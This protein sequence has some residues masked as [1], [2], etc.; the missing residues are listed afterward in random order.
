[1]REA[2][3]PG[4]RLSRARRSTKILVSLGML[5]LFL[6]LVSSLFVASAR[7]GLT[8]NSVRTYYV[9]E[10]SPGDDSLDGALLA[11]A[12]R[13]FAELVE[14]THLHILGGSMLLFLLCHLLS[15]CDVRDEL[16]SFLYICSFSSFLLTFA[17][18][19]L[20]IYLHVGFAYLYAPAIIVLLISL[21]ALTAIPLWEMW[22]RRKEASWSAE[23][24]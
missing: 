5:G 23:S 1:M 7:T 2:A 24:L 8:P 16:R 12:G 20:I 10:Q 21:V 13:P 18:P 17:L 9:G 6:G 3:V 22:A 11:S 15:V 19:W 14:V 4:Y